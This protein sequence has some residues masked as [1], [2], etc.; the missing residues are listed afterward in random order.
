MS[1][2]PALRSDARGR[3]LPPAAAAPGLPSGNGL[4]EHD[5]RILLVEDNDWDARQAEDAMG[6]AVPAPELRRT[7]SLALALQALGEGAF[8]LIL[9]D[10]N[11]PDSK[12]VATVARLRSAAAGTPIVA[13]TGSGD[14]DIG[15][16]C[17]DA[18]AQDFVE[19]GPDGPP[20]DLPQRVALSV[21]RHKLAADLAASASRRERAIDEVGDYVVTTDL[22]GRPLRWNS[23][24][25]A[26]MGGDA[27][28]RAAPSSPE[29]AAARAQV[30]SAMAELARGRAASRE[31]AM[32]T[33]GGL[34][35]VLWN[36]AP[37][38]DSSGAVVAV[39]AVG[40]DVTA[41]RHLEA[42][43]ASAREAIARAERLKEQDR[44]RTL[45]VN[46]IAHE[47]NNPLTPIRL[48]LAIAAQ[49]R[50]LFSPRL[51][52]AFDVVRRNTE[53]LAGLIT[54]LLDVGR[55]G[56][57]RLR[58]QPQEVDLGGFCDELMALFGAQAAAH[59]VTLEVRAPASCRVL[60]DPAR[61]AQVVVNLVSNA[62]KFT[63]PKGRVVVQ[64]GAVPGGF[65]IEVTDSGRGMDAEQMAHLFRPFV[66]VHADSLDKGG[67]GLGLYISKGIV[68]AHGGTLTCRSAGP[69]KGSTFTVTLPDRP[70]SQPEAGSPSAARPG[71]EG[72]GRAQAGP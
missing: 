51:S 46:A 71:P 52:K 16:L 60:A 40:R 30:A 1:G 70:P 34:R 38:R 31:L 53:R 5:L 35:R 10:L 29:D 66:Q 17:L 6:R 3:F 47:L 64:G 67:L 55:L 14:L 32:P 69:G 57:G 20:A 13:L 36:G 21:R 65:T 54:D 41:L 61:L 37:V 58:V 12:G 27:A 45:F 11:L 18:G 39:V 50:T 72:K 44:E 42:E 68:E 59:Q 48:Q 63:P 8:D 56:S 49:D 62:I 15:Y 7:A 23:S 22:D 43:H 33:P 4:P 28:V 9:S 2:A 19:K 24:F 26:V 25:A